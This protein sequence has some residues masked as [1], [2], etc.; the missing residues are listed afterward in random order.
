MAAEESHR[1]MG[2]MLHGLAGARLLCCWMGGDWLGLLSTGLRHMAT[3]I[4]VLLANTTGK[5]SEQEAL[6]R[7]LTNV[8]KVR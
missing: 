1:Q 5:G 6:S 4:V 2:Q 7:Y 8:N 3:A